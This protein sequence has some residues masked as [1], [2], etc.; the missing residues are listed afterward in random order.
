MWGGASALP[1]GF[2]PALFTTKAR[3][4]ASAHRIALTYIH[5]TRHN[6]HASKFG[7]NRTEQ[8]SHQRSEHAIDFRAAIAVSD[9]PF[10]LLEQDRDV[11]GE[12]GWLLGGEKKQYEENE[13]L[14]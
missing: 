1:P 6:V 13:N 8:K 9:D 3:P 2:C 14:R 12:H 5:R 11:G 7:S 4:R 10:V